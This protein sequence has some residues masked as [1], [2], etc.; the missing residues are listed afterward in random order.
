MA[1]PEIPDP[2]GLPPEPEAK[3]PKGPA[4][5]AQWYASGAADRKTGKGTALVVT[6]LLF[7]A[8]AGALLALFL[9][10]TDPIDPYVIA[11]PIVEYKDPAL[12]PIAWTRRDAE[13]IC[14]CYPA[15]KDN[16]G[17]N[18]QI[19]GKFLE[20][21]KDISRLADRWAADQKRKQPFDPKRPLVVYVC[22]YG[23]VAKGNVYLLPS[24]ADPGNPATWVKV[25]DILKAMED[26]AAG[27]KLLLLDLARPRTNPFTGPLADDVAGRLDELLTKYKGPDGADRLPCPVLVSCS[28]GEVSHVIPDARASAFAFYLAEGLRGEARGYEPGRSGERKKDD[29]VYL[30]EIAEFVPARVQR[31]AL[32]NVGVT[33]TPKYYNRG[34]E[35]IDFPVRLKPAPAD[36]PAFEKLAYAGF[37]GP[38]QWDQRDKLPPPARLAA[39]PELARWEAVLVRADA[40]YAATADAKSAIDPIDQARGFWRRAQDAAAAGGGPAYRALARARSQFD[41]NPQP[42]PIKKLLP[43]LTDYL[44]AATADKPEEKGIGEKKAKFLEAARDQPEVAAQGVWQWLTRVSRPGGQ[45]APAAYK[46]AAEAM[47]GLLPR[48]ALYPEADQVRAIAHAEGLSYGTYSQS[49]AADAKATLLR[50]EDASARALVLGP[51]GFL[52]ARDLLDDADGKKR[53]A[54]QVFYGTGP[55]GKLPSAADLAT[56]AVQLGDAARLFDAAGER[57]RAIGK[58]REDAARSV[59]VLA[60]TAILAAETGNTDIEAEWFDL[61]EKLLPVVRDLDQPPRPASELPTGRIADA[62]DRLAGPTA[63]LDDHWSSAAVKKRTT[64]NPPSVPADVRER[65]IDLTVPLLSLGDRKLVWDAVRRAATRFHDKTRK[66]QDAE[67]NKSDARTQPAKHPAPRPDGAARRAKVSLKLLELAGYENLADVTRA[68]A[69]SAAKDTPDA[70]AEAADALR[71]AWTKGLP[72]QIARLE[73]KGE[74]ARAERAARVFPSGLWPDVGRAGTGKNGVVEQRRAEQAAFRD[75]LRRHFVAYGTIRKGVP[76]AADS[77]DKALAEVGPAP[78]N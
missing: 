69:D 43:V 2:L 47:A 3:A 6:T 8:V 36:D 45:R 44:A 30:K 42:E 23:A 67:E 7:V 78:G 75:W 73:E 65:A 5:A 33:Q 40:T 9:I 60:A 48:D 51:D 39:G 31:W 21:L 55:G 24:D 72:D 68:V 57:M 64:D 70:R 10:P 14:D 35:G 54:E 56:A 4:P 27:N 58:A 46:A 59:R 34:V 17:V 11:I 26:C 62:A 1:A 16:T 71:Q 50:A 20:K 12:P 38:A 74:L 63:A 25:E 61:A 49:A 76:G 53:R 37:D 29:R 52:W 41:A 15:D 77:Y 32:Q 22:G 19:R 13:L 28:R 66:D 18:A